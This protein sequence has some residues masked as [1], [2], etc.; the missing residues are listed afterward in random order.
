MAKVRGPLF[1]FEA[2]G[3][4]ADSIVYFDWKGISAVRSWTKP[5]NPRTAAQQTQRGYLADAVDIWHA[6]LY[7]TADV[8]AWDQLAAIQTTP[9]SGFN[10]MVRRYIDCKVAGNVW[11][12]L[13]DGSMSEGTLYIAAATSAGGCVAY[14]GEKPTVLTNTVEMTY[15]E[16][17][18]YW[19]GVPSTALWP[20]GQERYVQ[21]RN[22]ATGYG[23]VT[24]IYKFLR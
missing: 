17:T 4:L 11:N 6:G 5:A 12:T 3:K 8:A 14:Y 15:N 18:K 19:S 13:Y 2:A 20:V 1:S 10:E 23:T 9:R 21:F 24:G 22:N 16:T 7:T